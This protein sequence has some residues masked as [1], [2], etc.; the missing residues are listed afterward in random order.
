MVIVGAVVGGATNYLAIKMLFRPYNPI[1]IKSFRLPFTP[2]LIPKRRAEIARH[3]GNTVSDYLLTPD[4][5]Q[6][7]FFNEE[8][9]GKALEFAQGKTADLVLTRE[10]TIQDWL[11]TFGMNHLPEKLEGKVDS[12]IDFQYQKI[13][14]T[15]ST[16]AIDE[17]LPEN[18]N[19]YVDGKIPEVVDAL[20]NKGVA[21]LS[22]SAG[23]VTIKNMLD[24]FLSGKGMFG[25]FFSFLSDS[26]TVTTKIQ[27]E[28]VNIL[29]SSE[30]KN[31]LNRILSD[32][33]HK[34]K[35]K[36][37]MDY[38]NDLD[39][40]GFAQ[41]FA[42][43]AKNQM[44]FE[45]RLNKPLLEYW[46]DGE[47]YVN[48]VLLPKLIDNGFEQVEKNLVNILQKVN[49]AELVREQVDSFPIEK[50]EEIVIGIAKRELQMITFLG[51]F[52][53]GLVGI[54]QGLFVILFN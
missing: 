11:D 34:L 15:L 26:S 17:I 54:L 7:K 9:K 12:V 40:D 33:W 19:R 8:M 3:L 47:K 30:T 24:E 1:Y 16:K 50:L 32:E 45:G 4:V 28:L 27:Q 5:F 20:A 18:V 39:L 13:K 22:S 35:Q 44:D 46:P 31:F 37:A 53:G 49:L 21:Y 2:G 25:S 36:P 23:E 29:Q 52:I 43:Y 41:K 14:Y 42:Q 51:A 6:K 38:L 10:K 48:N